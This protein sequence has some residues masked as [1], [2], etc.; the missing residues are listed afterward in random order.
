MKK[1]TID[2]NFYV[3]SNHLKI[4]IDSITEKLH[5]F[6]LQLCKY[7]QLENLKNFNLN[8]ESYGRF[9]AEIFFKFL[10]KYQEV[11]VAKNSTFF[12]R[13]G[14]LKKLKAY[15]PFLTEQVFHDIIF[16][17]DKKLS[18]NE[19]YKIFEEVYSQPIKKAIYVKFNCYLKFFIGDKPD[20]PKIR[21]MLYYKKISDKKAVDLISAREKQ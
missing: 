16:K 2:I 17:M 18:K 1:K 15:G 21:R 19:V 12:P 8:Q 13:K 10:N 11:L 4:S 20:I 6:S 5:R 7:Y 14:S 9:T 3:D